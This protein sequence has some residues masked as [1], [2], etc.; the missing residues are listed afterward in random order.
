LTAEIAEYAEKGR[1][2]AVTAKT[3]ELLRKKDI[4]LP[5]RRVRKGYI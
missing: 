1:H 3:A 4:S 5:R 2:E